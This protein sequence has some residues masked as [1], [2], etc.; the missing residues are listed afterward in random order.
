MITTLLEVD[1]RAR[2]DRVRFSKVA[3]VGCSHGVCLTADEF[4]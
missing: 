3:T 4:A 2:A 1:G